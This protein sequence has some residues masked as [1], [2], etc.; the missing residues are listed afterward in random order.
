MAINIKIPK[1]VTTVDAPENSSF[2]V[3]ITFSDNLETEFQGVS[4]IHIL[5]GGG[6]WL[7]QEDGTWNDV[8]DGYHFAAISLVEKA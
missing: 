7:I 4:K 8:P 2:T 3:V 6:Y 5:P 1:D